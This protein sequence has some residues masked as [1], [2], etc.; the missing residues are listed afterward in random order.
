MRSAIVS[1]ATAMISLVWMIC[2]AR[3][4]RLAKLRSESLYLAADRALGDGQNWASNEGSMARS[5]VF[6]TFSIFLM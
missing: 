2:L 1:T 3:S 5:D 4:W 6:L